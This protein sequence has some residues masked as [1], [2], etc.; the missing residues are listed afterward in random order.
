MLQSDLRVAARRFRQHPGLAALN[1]AGLALGLACCL[2]IALF[3]RDE[4]SFDRSHPEVERLYRLEQ[5]LDAA[6]TGDVER[7]DDVKADRSGPRSAKSTHRVTERHG[8]SRNV[9]CD[10]TVVSNVLLAVRVVSGTCR[11]Q[12]GYLE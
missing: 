1:V 12:D 6:G 3:V 2:L 4:L 8:V 7:Q 9:A 10:M 5:D 11:E